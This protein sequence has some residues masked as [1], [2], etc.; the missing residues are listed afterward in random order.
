METLKKIDE[1]FE[2]IGEIFGFLTDHVFPIIGVIW[3][4]YLFLKSL[5][6]YIEDWSWLGVLLCLLHWAAGPLLIYFGVEFGISIL[7]GCGG[8]VLLSALATGA[9][10]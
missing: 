4:G 8:L 2:V 9:E 7:L 5:G 6:A 1:F 3:L 10:D